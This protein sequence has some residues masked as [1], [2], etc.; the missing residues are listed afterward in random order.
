V[1]VLAQ[2]GQLGVGADDVLA[3]V[4]RVR[5]GVADALDALDRVDRPQQLG[6]LTGAAARRR[7]R[8]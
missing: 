8:P 2:R 5:A 6:E 4:L 3:H 7:S 1:D